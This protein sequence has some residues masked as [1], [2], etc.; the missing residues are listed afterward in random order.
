MIKNE[1]VFI[2]T[3]TVVSVMLSDLALAAEVLPDLFEDRLDLDLE[4]EC[5]LSSTTGQMDM[6]GRM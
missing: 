5:C 2:H 6:G 3:E 4:K 1:S